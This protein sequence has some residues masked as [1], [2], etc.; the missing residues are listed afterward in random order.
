MLVVW[1]TAQGIWLFPAYLYEFMN[2]NTAL[3]YVW[4]ASV[5]F[6]I[7]NLAIARK[8]VLAYGRVVAKKQQVK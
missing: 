1:L 2:L 4:L 6:L 8:L 5:V 3:L 7:V